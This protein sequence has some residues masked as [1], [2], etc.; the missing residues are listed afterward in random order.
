MDY[1]EQ[2]ADSIDW[3]PELFLVICLVSAAI[4]YLIGV[5]SWDYKPGLPKYNNPL[6]QPPRKSF[7]E[8]LSISLQSKEDIYILNQYINPPKETET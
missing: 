5:C 7:K 1:F 8:R 3:T 6:P 2:I 4:L